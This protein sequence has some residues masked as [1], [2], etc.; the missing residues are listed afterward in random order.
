MILF[1]VLSKIDLESVMTVMDVE[2]RMLSLNRG[3]GRR[4]RLC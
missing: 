3:R 2:V 4:G 1:M